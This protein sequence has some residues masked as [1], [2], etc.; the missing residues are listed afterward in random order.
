M[1]SIQEI[2]SLAY[3]KTE[4]I[5]PSQPVNF[6]LEKD[7]KQQSYSIEPAKFH[8]AL[9]SK[10][11]N[12]TKYFDALSSHLHGISNII[13]AFASTP[14]SFTDAWNMKSEEL[15][16]TD[17]LALTR[18]GGHFQFNQLLGTGSELY[19]TSYP[20]GLVWS[21][22]SSIVKGFRHRTGGIYKED[23]LNEMG[24]FTYA[25][26]TDAAGMME[27]RFVEQFCEIIGIPMVYI[28]TQWFKYNT[29]YEEQNNWLYMTGAAKVVSIEAKPNAPIKLQLISKDDALKNINTLADAIKTKGSYKVRPPMPE[30]IRL[31]WSYDKIKGEKRKRLINYAKVNRLT[32]PSS[33]CG[34]VSF[35]SLR[36]KDIHV[37]HRISQNW[38]V[39][40]YGIADVNHPYNLYLSCGACNISLSDRYPTQLE[41]AINEMGTL[42]DWLMSGLL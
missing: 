21:K 22:G 13:A 1:K 35:T 28:I 37:S 41:E 36:D 18:S 20:K 33:D 40:N 8:N 3:S 29:P 32:C 26:P 27:Y 7:N 10:Y 25:T 34:H 2:Y 39:Q 11:Q 30:H 6:K 5:I 14:T 4:N 19:R 15:N 17:V 12:S 31:G 38:N 23:N 24:V 16:K 42:G 9:K